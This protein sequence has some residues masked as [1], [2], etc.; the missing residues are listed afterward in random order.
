MPSHRF[1]DP[2]RLMRLLGVTGQ[3]AMCY[4]TAAHPEPTAKLP[5]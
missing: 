2:L 5:G 3:S 1:A 4:V